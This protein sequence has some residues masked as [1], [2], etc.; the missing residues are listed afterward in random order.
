[1]S[2]KLTDT[3][4]VILSAAAPARRSLSG[5]AEESEGKTPPRK[6]QR[7]FSLAALVREELRPRRALA[8]WR[9]DDESGQSYCLN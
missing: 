1:M 8:V 9:R 6:W 4:L 3:Q 7:N 2:I 5:G